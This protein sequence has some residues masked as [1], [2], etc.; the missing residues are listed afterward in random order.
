MSFGN[1]HSYASLIALKTNTPEIISA[2]RLQKGQMWQ[3]KD[4]NLQIGLVGKR[5]VHYKHYRG[6]NKRPPLSIASIKVLE[7]YLDE[8]KAVLSPAD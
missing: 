5:L 3:M 8:N 1:H 7:E 4:S 2:S 6:K